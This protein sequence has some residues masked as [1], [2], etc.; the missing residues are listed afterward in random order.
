MHDDLGAEEAKNLRRN[1]A[2]NRLREPMK[3]C[4]FS[5]HA[6]RRTR[7]H[8]PLLSFLPQPTSHPRS[9]Q[10]EY[11]CRSARAELSCKQL[12]LPQPV[13]LF[14]AEFPLGRVLPAEP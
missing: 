1:F 6:Q 13:S 4:E 10:R 5:R 7:R 11:V 3:L 14:P 12:P 8:I 2:P 9:I